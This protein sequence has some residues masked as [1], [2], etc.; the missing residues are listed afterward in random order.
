MIPCWRC[1][2]KEQRLG[3]YCPRCGW[4]R[5]FYLPRGVPT[6][7]RL[8]ALYKSGRFTSSL[9]DGRATVLGRRQ[10]L[11]PTARFRRAIC[12]LWARASTQLL[13]T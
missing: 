3:A 11:S 13:I 2:R 6:Q 8:E 4:E 1:Q 10:Q 7:Q 9:P 12:T 5:R